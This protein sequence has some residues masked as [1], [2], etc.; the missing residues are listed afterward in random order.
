MERFIDRLAPIEK[1]ELKPKIDISDSK[2]EV[3]SNN[4]AVVV[5][6]T[7]GKELHAGHLFLLSIADQT[8]SSIVAKNPLTLIN[9]NK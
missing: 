6:V 4:S 2:E 1:K 5:S 7:L 3:S 8:A 9:N